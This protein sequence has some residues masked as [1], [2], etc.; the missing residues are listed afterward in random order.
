M[1]ILVVIIQLCKENHFDKITV[2]SVE[3]ML[4]NI[5]GIRK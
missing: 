4:A 3:F 5:R 2:E 1:I